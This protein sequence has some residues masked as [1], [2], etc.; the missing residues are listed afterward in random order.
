MNPLYLL[1]AALGLLALASG[2]ML[3]LA[4]PPQPVALD[5]P[6][7][8]GDQSDEPQAEMPQGGPL[9]AVSAILSTVDLGALMSA[10]QD[11]DTA[12]RNTAAFLMLIRRAEGT[13][14]AGGYNRIFGGASFE[15]MSDHPHK[16]VPFTDR[17]TGQRLYSTA[18]GAYQFM[19]ASQTPSGGWTKVNT[20]GVLK[21]RIGLQDFSPASQDRAAVQLI[22]DAGAL[23][24]VQ[25]GNVEAAVQKV[26]R[27]WASMPG[28]G[29]GQPEK[30]MAYLRDVYAAAG[31]QFA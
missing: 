12:A 6:Q 29:Y 19:A 30:T 24:D 10:A 4:G 20:W 15:D 23:R 22:T 16:A 8:D 26:R 25:A 11:T 27:I 1:A 18:A 9:L 13:A 7:M 17:R 31:G 14:D 21:A 2:S 3:D 5:T 28:A